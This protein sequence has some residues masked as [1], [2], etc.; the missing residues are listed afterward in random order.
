MRVST[1]QHWPENDV[2]FFGM[3]RFRKNHTEEFVQNCVWHG[4]WS[5]SL[6]T[7]EAH[8]V[9]FPKMELQKLGFFNFNRK[10]VERNQPDE[11]KQSKR[12]RMEQMK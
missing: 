9:G 3:P 1:F 11:M 4:C 12:M 7:K 2:I 5:F 10:K 6:W 8:R